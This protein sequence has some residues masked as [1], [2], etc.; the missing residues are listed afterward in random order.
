[1]RI[2]E[3]LLLLSDPNEPAGP[4]LPSVP[5]HERSRVERPCSISA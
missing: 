5:H 2:G 1:M 4:V 3:D